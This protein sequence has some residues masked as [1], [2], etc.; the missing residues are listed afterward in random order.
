MEYG[1][2]KSC[3]FPREEVETSLNV[4]DYHTAAGGEE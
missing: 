3:L 2:W 1:V 4:L